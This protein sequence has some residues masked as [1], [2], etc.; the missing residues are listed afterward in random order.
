MD[1]K[2]TISFTSSE[3]ITRFNRSNFKSNYWKLASTFLTQ[4]TQTFCGVASSVTVLNAAPIGKPITA[5]YAPHEYFTQD[6]YF[7]EAVEEIVPH[8]QVLK[9]GMTLRQLCDALNLWKMH[10]TCNHAGLVSESDFRK[11]VM[12]SCEQ[13]GQY[14]IVN[15]LRTMLG[16]EGGGHF[17]PIAA[18]DKRTDSILVLDVA[19]YKYLPFWVDLSTLYLA[20]RT[21]DNSSNQHRGWAFCSLQ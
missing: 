21:I 19:R 5:P 2:Q 11:E 12:G 7:S 6:N 4:K 1:I 14:I 9:E 17:S 3:G 13:E 10:A 15:F 8:S 20:M 18:F 16:Q